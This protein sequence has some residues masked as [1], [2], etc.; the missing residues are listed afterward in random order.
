VGQVAQQLAAD[1]AALVGGGDVRVADQGDVA[2][3][4]DAH[5]A[6][7][8][9]AGL[10]A[11]EGDPGGDLFL[12][13]APCHVRLVPAVGGDHA[14]VGLGRRVDDG[15]DGGALVVAARPDAAHDGGIYG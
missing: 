4:L 13:L 14:A 5:D 2:D 10:S 15:E 9:A 11:P 8:L 12:E 3:G 1:A 6:E 7:Q